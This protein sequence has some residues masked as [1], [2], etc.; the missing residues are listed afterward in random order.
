MLDTH[1]AVIVDVRS[2][3]ESINLLLGEVETSAG[4][5]LAQLRPRF[6]QITNTEIWV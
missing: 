1:G 6:Y 3:E 4:E 2:L 5:S